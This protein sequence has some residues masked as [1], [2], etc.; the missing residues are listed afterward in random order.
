[1]KT[2]TDPDAG[3]VD[4]SKVAPTTVGYLDGLAAPAS[5]PQN[6]RVAPVET[7]VWSVTATLT[8]YR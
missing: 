5:T 4:T 3:S 7:T 6:G 8:R 2:G 1:V